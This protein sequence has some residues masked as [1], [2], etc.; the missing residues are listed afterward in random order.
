MHSWNQLRSGFA[1]ARPVDTIRIK[2]GSGYIGSVLETTLVDA[3]EW[4]ADGV[5]TGVTAD[6]FTVTLAYE[7]AAMTFRTGGGFISNEIELFVPSDLDNFLMWLD[8]YDAS[9]YIPGTGAGMIAL[10]SRVG[11]IT[12]AQT[13]AGLQPTYN[14]TGRNGKPAF[15]FTSTQRMTSTN[16]A[17]FPDNAEPSSLIGL[18]YNS[19]A[20]INY[21]ALVG[22]GSLNTTGNYRIIGKAS[23]GS[24]PLVL[25]ESETR[26][27]TA[28]WLDSDALIFGAHLPARQDIA[29]NGGTINT[30]AITLNTGANAYANLG[31]GRNDDPRQWEGS[32]HELLL[33]GD[34]VTTTERQKLEGYECHRWGYTSLL[35]SGHPYKNIAPRN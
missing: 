10:V 32:F 2:T 25:A 7:G 31:M 19:A 17:A 3:G 13:T 1:A 26:D 14:A 28:V 21:R 35:P 8:A 12:W 6:E 24:R 27:D 34:E 33:F 23:S 4:Y 16:F 15:I 30:N 9:S 18:G 29:F 20:G 11:S 22:W 5:G